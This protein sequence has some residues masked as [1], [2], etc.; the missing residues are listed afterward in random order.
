MAALKPVFYGLTG[1]VT[2]S[3]KATKRSGSGRFGSFL[4]EQEKQFLFERSSATWNRRLNC[5][6]P[7][8]LLDGL[9]HAAHSAAR[10]SAGTTD[11]VIFVERRRIVIAL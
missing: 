1:A 3:R 10:L 9:G 8:P 5:S 2:R 4:Q 7:K 6:L 11:N